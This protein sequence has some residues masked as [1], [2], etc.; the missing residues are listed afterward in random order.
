LE[1]CFPAFIAFL[2]AAFVAARSD[3]L[4]DAHALAGK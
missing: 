2:L 1:N 4:R 3:G